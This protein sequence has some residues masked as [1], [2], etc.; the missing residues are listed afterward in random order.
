MK[1]TT[2]KKGTKIFNVEDGNVY[3]V[4]KSNE[5]ITKYTD[6]VR[7]TGQCGTSYLTEHFCVLRKRVGHYAKG[8]SLV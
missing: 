4:I 6:G 5:D 7:V 8:R 1:T 2:Y 3:T